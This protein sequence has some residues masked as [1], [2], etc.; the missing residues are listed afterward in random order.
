MSLRPGELTLLAAE[1]TRELPG[2]AVQK[3][4]APTQSRVYLE[5]RVPGRTVTLLLCAEPG[6]ARLSAVEERPANPPSPPGWQAVL[7]RELLGAR[8]RDAEALP[9]RRTL[10]LHFERR[11]SSGEVAEDGAEPSE[12][13]RAGLPDSGSHRADDA[14]APAEHGGA[15]SADGGDDASGLTSRGRAGLAPGESS[16]RVGSSA[17]AQAGHARWGAEVPDARGQ[18]GASE[19]TVS[20]ASERRK[21]GKART[22]D[23]P[24]AAAGGVVFRTLV[25]EVGAEPLLVL[26]TGKARVLAL[27]SPARAGLR[28]G[29]T[30]TPLEERPTQTAPSRLAS[31]FVHLRLAH[32][33]EALFAP[34]EQ[35]RWTDAR[36][37]PLLARLKRLAR[38]REKVRGDLERTERADTFRREGEL[39]AQNLFRISRGATSVTVPE[40]L[41]DGTTRDVTITLDPKRSPKAEVDW[42]FHQYKRL[43]R[44]AELARARLVSLDEEKAA[45]EAQLARLEAEPARGPPP[46]TLKAGREGQAPLPPYREYLGRGG[47]RIW[48]GRGAAH[49]D[50]L[51]FHVARPFHVWLH[52]RGVPGAHVVVPLEKNAQLSGEVLIDAAHLALHHSDLKGEPRG[53]VSYTPVKFVRKAKD[54]P[55]GAVTFTREK[56]VLVRVEKER[57]D[58]LLAQD[59]SR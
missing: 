32:G 52:A 49:N 1:L 47:Q 43:Q 56:T 34:L 51:T 5:L 59:E 17:Q 10:L 33:A 44:G 20:R 13:G 50:A 24:S 54:A 7:R 30:W 16:L 18:R 38:T 41:D 2:A 12:R 40:Y 3:V 31:D 14:W 22:P 28:V 6:A 35:A 11:V 42:R 53:E 21:K 37:A 48:V 26:L 19:R 55:P 46:Q 39:L 25:L 9:A 45:L 29:A 15:G 27:S 57:L 58:R 36:K 4:S 8:L 23:G